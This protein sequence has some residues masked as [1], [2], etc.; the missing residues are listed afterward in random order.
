MSAEGK[1]PISYAANDP[2]ILGRTVEQLL[3]QLQTS[4]YD[5]FAAVSLPTRRKERQTVTPDG[6]SP[7]SVRR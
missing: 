1:V 5:T 2:E 7:T 6:K 3:A 4:Q